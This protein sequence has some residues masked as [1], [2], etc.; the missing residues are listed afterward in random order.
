MILAAAECGRN[1]NADAPPE[2][3]LA[4]Q[5]MSYHALPEPGGL[6]D[7]PAGMLARMTRLYNVWIAHREY[8]RRDLEH[9]LEWQK[10]N[11]DLFDTVLRTNRLRDDLKKGNPDAQL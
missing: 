11:Q 3:R 8:H 2:L 10:A 4:W 1:P 9:A 5:A 6:L 7:Q